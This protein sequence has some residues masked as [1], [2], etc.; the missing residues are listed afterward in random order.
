M[1][2][3]IK[4]WNFPTKKLLFQQKVQECIQNLLFVKRLETIVFIDTVG[5]IGFWKED[6]FHFKMPEEMDLEVTTES[7][8]ETTKV[9]ITNMETNVLEK[10][11]PELT[12]LAMEEIKKEVETKKS[13]QQKSSADAWIDAAPQANFHSSETSFFKSRRF[14][15]WN[16]I[17]SIIVRR[18]N[19]CNFLDIDFAD[20]NFHKNIR[21]R[22]MYNLEMGDMNYCGAILASRALEV[23]DNEYEDEIHNDETKKFSFIQFKCFSYI[24]EPCDWTVKLQK[25]EVY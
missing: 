17:G 5:Q 3:N 25:G 2:K 8:K 10:K 23:N 22:D 12:D 7:N 19:E 11:M 4:I 9:D 16:L 18:D 1:D 24:Y 21:S 20:K 15:C 13:I 6:E 14:L